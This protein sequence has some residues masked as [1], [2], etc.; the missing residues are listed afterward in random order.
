MDLLNTDSIFMSRALEAA[1]LARAL[2]EVPIGAVLVF[3]G[4]VIASGYN[5]TRLD[6]DPTAHAEVVAL[7]AAARLLGNY[8]LLDTTL[9]ATIEPCAMCAGA[10]IWARVSRLV[11]GAP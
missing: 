10:L 11:Y 1:E 2:D 7:R 9:Y 6:N 8:R 4:Q 5:R 3:E